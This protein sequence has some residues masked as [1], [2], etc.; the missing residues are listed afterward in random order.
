LFAVTVAVAV[1]FDMSS[2]VTALSALEEPLDINLAK[3]F[4]TRVQ[5]TLLMYLMM[6]IGISVVNGAK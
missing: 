4:F 2:T 1:I 6:L 5:E 3:A